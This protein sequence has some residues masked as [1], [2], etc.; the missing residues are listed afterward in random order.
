MSNTKT[1]LDDEREIL[2]QMLRDKGTPISK[3][4][5][6]EM[7][8]IHNVRSLNNCGCRKCAYIEDCETIPL[9]RE[10]LIANVAP[11]FNMWEG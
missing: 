4:Q 6:E 9:L 8:S 7:E 1:A 11:I 10:Y 5:V 2:I 3:L